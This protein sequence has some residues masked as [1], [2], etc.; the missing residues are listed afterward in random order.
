MPAEISHFV[1]EGAGSLA[2]EMSGSSKRR[3]SKWDHKDSEALPENFYD[4]AQ[5]RRPREPVSPVR[6][7]RRHDSRSRESPVAWDRE[8]NCP[9][10]SPGLD[11]WRPR[12]SSRSPRNGWSRSHRISKSRSRS[13]SRSQSPAHNF[14]REPAVN[15]RSR[16]RSGMSPQ[17]CKDFAGGRCRRGSS[18]H[19]LHQ[20]AQLYDNRRPLE[21]DPP[22]DWERRRRSG[23]S[24]YSSDDAKDNAI[25]TD[26]SAHICNDF[27]KGRCRR[28]DSCRYMHHDN[29][30]D[31]F[32]KGSVEDVYRNRDHE[33]RSRDTYYDHDHDRRNRDTYSDHEH[34]R[35]DTYPDRN[36]ESEPPKRLETPCKFFAAGN[37]RNGTR[38]RFSHQVQESFSPERRSRED[39]RGPD[40]KF[41]SGQVRDGPRWSDATT[42]STVPAVQGWKE[43]KK[44]NNEVNTARAQSDGK[45]ADRKY[46]GD[47][48]WD[49]PSWSDTL[50]V[51][52]VTVVHGWGED[53]NESAELTEDMTR[54][55]HKDDSSSH[56]RLDIN[57]TWDT[58]P[59]EKPQFQDKK[60]LLL[61]YKME[62]NVPSLGHFASGG[63]ENL[64]GDMEIS[65]R[66]TKQQAVKSLTSQT[67][68][69]SNISF[70][71]V[72]PDAAGEASFEKNYHT[73]LQEQKA[74]HDT[75]AELHPIFN[76][77]KPTSYSGEKRE[78][79]RDHDGAFII[80]N[81]AVN[82]PPEHG[83]L[84]SD[85]S[86]S[87]HPISH[88]NLP[89]GNSQ[90]S[91]S[92]RPS[93][94]ET[95]QVS[96]NPSS[97]LDSKV[98]EG[99]YV[100]SLGQG[101]IVQPDL[102]VSAY[103][104]SNT[105][106]SLGQTQLSLPPHPSRGETMQVSQNPSSFLD[107][108]VSDG[109]HEASLA[110]S[111]LAPGSVTS[112]GTVS[113]E[114][115][116]QLSH[117]TASLTQLLESR[118][119]L[120]QFSSAAASL[121]MSNLPDLAA[122]VPPVPS[123]VIQSNQAPEVLKQYDPVCNSI[124]PKI[125]NLGNHLLPTAEQKSINNELHHLGNS[126]IHHEGDNVNQQEPLVSFKDEENGKKAFE[127][128][129]KVPENGPSEDVGADDGDHD[130]KKL[131]DIKGIRP[132]KFALAEFVKELLKPYWKDGQVSKEA[133]KTIVKKVVDKVTETL[134]PQIPQTKEKIDL[135]LSC[136]KPKIEK[137]VQ[138][139]VGKHLKG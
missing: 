107:H 64:S 136:S 119:Q 102:N 112:H 53:K 13:R 78:T 60:Q 77:S 130:G 28:G 109:S 138:A 104:I 30:G 62:D 21:C 99:S 69:I 55:G 59:T 127:E 15:D 37:C 18:C 124:E 122:P 34:R 87:V 113:N 25:R 137:L 36:H 66:V 33:H 92:S 131:K 40:R 84:Q 63:V 35:K 11:E 3:H 39:R 57:Q 52:N 96:H 129:I 117:L 20:D 126:E 101:G 83:L 58:L 51:P 88:V 50:I 115:L 48:V 22:D 14:R 91:F 125:P 45:R 44:E 31:V 26:K 90:L 68:S 123:A 19:F 47:Q 81:Q 46:E 43:D 12:H 93:P 105:N 1:F 10:I 41:E 98:G 82:V 128:R 118:Q 121:G 79:I 5:P 23:G 72:H 103:P 61:Q 17:I 67:P 94:G 42:V 24:R 32:E 86:G 85:P 29:A 108:K 120:S 139:Y 56:V 65:P 76:N 71:D 80:Q 38:C 4:R 8:G 73:G 16:S 97:F 54:G 70:A 6:G 2:E 106:S 135:Y 7:S 75:S 27:L 133:Y 100:A 114:Q 134:G 9:R 49:G 95:M 74:F 110:S 111:T 89:P 132:F 116:A